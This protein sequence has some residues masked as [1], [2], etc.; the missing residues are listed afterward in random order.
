MLSLSLHHFRDLGAWA[1]GRTGGFDKGHNRYAITA[2]DCCRPSLNR[3]DAAIMV[4][5]SDPAGLTKVRASCLAVLVAR[6]RA[7]IYS[8]LSPQYV[9][10]TPLQYTSA[11]SEAK[12]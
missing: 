11:N 2:P 10:T 4:P 8:V 12:D 3:R 5:M 7:E 1:Y 9:C 6:V